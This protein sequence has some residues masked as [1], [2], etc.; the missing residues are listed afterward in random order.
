MSSSTPVAPPVNFM[1]SGSFLCFDTLASS[2]SAQPATRVVI[3]ITA[4]GI[5]QDFIREYYAP[6]SNNRL[7]SGHAALWMNFWCSAVATGVILVHLIA[8]GLIGEVVGHA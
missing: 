2:P 3:T 4:E 1:N 7:V 8:Y 6:Q 5:I